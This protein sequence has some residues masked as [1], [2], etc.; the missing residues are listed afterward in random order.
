MWRRNLLIYSRVAL[1]SKTLPG[2]IW[3][4]KILINYINFVLEFAEASN[5]CVNGLGATTRRE[6][7]TVSVQKKL[8]VRVL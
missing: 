4:I 7:Y 3:A 1:I 5:V 2:T 8:R 6:W